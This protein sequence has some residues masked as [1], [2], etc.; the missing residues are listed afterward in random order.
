MEMKKYFDVFAEAN[1]HP[2]AEQFSKEAR[3][4]IMLAE[5][6]Y[7]ERVNQALSIQELAKKAQTTSAVITR[8]EN[9][10]VSTSTDMIYRIFE[11]LGKKK[12][13]LTFT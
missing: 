11:A 10:Q 13:E 1:K 2:K 8:I 3:A 4:R 5:T 12:I 7:H 6:I 9:A